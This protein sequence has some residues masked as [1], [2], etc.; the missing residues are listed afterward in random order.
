MSH[1]PRTLLQYPTLQK[2]IN[3]FRVWHLGY[4]GLGPR[5]TIALCYAQR[6]LANDPCHCQGQA[7]VYDGG[8]HTLAFKKSG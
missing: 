8:K 7:G 2:R 1:V 5:V 3:F 4:K 6:P